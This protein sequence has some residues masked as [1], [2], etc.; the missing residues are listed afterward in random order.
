LQYTP[1]FPAEGTFVNGLIIRCNLVEN[2]VSGQSD[3]LEC[4]PNTSQFGSNINYSLSRDSHLI[5]LRKSL[6]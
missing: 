1:P 4:T 6:Q 3:V 5:K 2:L